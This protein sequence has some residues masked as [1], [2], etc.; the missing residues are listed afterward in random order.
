MLGF[1]SYAS[2]I[3]VALALFIFTYR[4]CIVRP[5]KFST[6]FMVVCLGITLVLK[7][8]TLHYLHL[9]P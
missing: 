9:L 4:W 1:L 6:V 3:L 8:I 5:V 2:T 7:L